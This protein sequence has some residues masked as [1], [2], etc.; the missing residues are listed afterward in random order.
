MEMGNSTVSARTLA[1]VPKSRSIH[2]QKLQSRRTPLV[3]RQNLLHRE[4]ISTPL[5]PA[6]VF[7][8]GQQIV[9]RHRKKS[10]SDESFECQRP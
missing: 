4:I 10:D 1:W 7:E 8:H 9:P 3:L 5:L 2:S 6:T